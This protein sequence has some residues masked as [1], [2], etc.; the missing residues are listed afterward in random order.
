MRKVTI[1][2]LILFLVAGSVIPQSNKMVYA[3]DSDASDL[4]VESNA[5]AVLKYKTTSDDDFDI[6]SLEIDSE[7]ISKRTSDSKT[8]RRV[9]GTYVMAIYNSVIHYEQDGELRDIDNSLIYDESTNDYAN[10]ANSFSIKFPKEIDKNKKFKLNYNDY[11]ISWTVTGIDK[12]DIN[13]YDDAKISNNLKDLANISQQ[14]VY[15]NV[16]DNVNL[17]YIL[18]GNEIKEN[19][20][21]EKYIED[22][23]M[24]F[25]YTLKDLVLVEDT[26]GDFV[27]MNEEN[28][29]IFLLNNMVMY[30][31]EGTESSDIGLVVNQIK[32][33]EYQIE[34]NP[35]D[36][37]LKNAHYPVT[38]DPTI[39]YY[40]DDNLIRDKYVFG[41]YSSDGSYIKAG[42]NG[43]RAY[44]SYLEFDISQ[45][46]EDVKINYAHLYLQTYSSGNYCTNDCTIVAK[47]V[48]ATVDYDDI[49]AEGL[50]IT[51]SREID[52]ANVLYS[53]GDTGTYMF[54]ITYNMQR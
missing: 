40:G 10:T 29:I 12:S 34:I 20:L 31:S 39:T 36:D 37:F 50:D 43:S 22:F 9:D 52:F 15:N 33:D 24:S 26:N 51:S 28:E 4:N 49:R 21:L 38:I 8:F 11:Q 48:L 5:D 47:E 53:D 18:N 14:L 16:Q 6:S 45:I 1:I 41:T 30:D 7:V 25:T 46:P 19:I 32:K 27:F 44:R 2:M 3:Y 35:N 17:E 13:Y 54:D 42:Y 23:T